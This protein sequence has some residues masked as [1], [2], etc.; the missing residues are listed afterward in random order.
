MRKG[1]VLVLAALCFLA[2]LPFLLI[3]VGQALFVLAA[4]LQ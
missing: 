4:L 2:C 1:C 3:L